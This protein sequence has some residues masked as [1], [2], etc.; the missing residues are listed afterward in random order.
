MQH[1][2]AMKC[3][4]RCGYTLCDLIIFSGVITFLGDSLWGFIVIL[5]I[6]GHYV[7]TLQ[8][9]NWEYMEVHEVYLDNYFIE[10]QHTLLLAS[11]INL[12]GNLIVKSVLISKH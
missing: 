11:L 7:R 2:L 6:S 9:S 4:I 3:F 1:S 5:L 12:D 8:S 10:K